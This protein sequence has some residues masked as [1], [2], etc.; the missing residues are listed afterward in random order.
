MGS[1]VLVAVLVYNGRA[2]VP[3]TLAS[4]AAMRDATL[5]AGTNKIEI[6]IFDD[7]S[8]EPGWSQTLAGLCATLELGY[9]CSP[10]NLGIPR[11]MTLAMLRGEAAGHDYVVLL[12]SDVV[13]PGNLVDAMVGAASAASSGG[14]GPVASIT[15]WSNNASIF[16]VPNDDADRYLADQHVVNQLAETLADEFDGTVTTLPVGMG[17]CLAVSTLAMKAVGVMDPVFGRG[18][19]EE[20]DWCCRATAMGWSHVLATN[21][22]VYHM[23]SATTRIAGLLAPGEQTVQVNESIIDERHPE[24]RRRVTNWEL[25][26]GVAPQVAKAV[27][28]IVADAARKRGY[29]LEATW[30]PKNPTLAAETLEERAHIIVAPDGSGPLVEAVV[31]GFRTP[32]AVGAEGILAAVAS[33]VGLAPSEVRISDHGSVASQLETAARAAGVPVERVVRYPERV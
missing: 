26:G 19:C 7:A 12:N 23:G 4:V 10:R 13:V 30:L 29:I 1:S 24:Y 17:F 11:N 6:V 2:F 14:Q 8:P 5:A 9:Y 20:V 15:A 27:R 21:T 28:R 31:D 32:I 3:R 18:Y 16:S 33:F 25:S 22:F